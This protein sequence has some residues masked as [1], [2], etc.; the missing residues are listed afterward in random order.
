MSPPSSKNLTRSRYDRNAF[1]YDFMEAPIEWFRFRKWRIRLKE[2]LGSGRILEV[3]VGTG[4]NLTYYPQNAEVTAIDFSPNMLRRA[5]R[6]AHRLNVQV[7]LL[8]MDVQHLDFPD[9]YFDTVFATF[10]FCSVPDP[11][12]GLSELHRVCKPDGRLI[13]LEHMR[14]G[15][16]ILGAVFDLLNPL[17]VRL[18]G[19]N[20]NRR[21]CSNISAAGW[22]IQVAERLA[23]DI[24]WWIEAAP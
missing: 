6:K 20:A 23:S 11:I 7:D 13:L 10:V 5:H 2:R 3:G 8:E 24:V 22:R 12:A 4:K 14:P 15:N 1:F 18:M 9:R 16:S 21:T 17:I 19:A